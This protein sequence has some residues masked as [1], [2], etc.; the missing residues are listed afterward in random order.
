[1]KTVLR[2]GES[3]IRNSAA[4][5][6]KGLETVGGK[7]WL[8]D[9]RLI[10]EAH[11]FNVQGGNTEIDFADIQGVR[12]CWTRFLGIIPLVPNSLAVSATDGREYR[13]VL[14]GRGA[15]ANAIDEA[16]KS[17]SASA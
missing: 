1:M 5:L 3:T 11:K 15:W 10:F 8:T 13:F 14:M 17:R 4:N 16:R 9:Q 6:Q 2:S 12:P 7:L